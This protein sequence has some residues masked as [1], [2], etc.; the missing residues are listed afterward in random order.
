MRGKR[1]GTASR[2]ENNSSFNQRNANISTKGESE[3]THN[4]N[5]LAKVSSDELANSDNRVQN[6]TKAKRRDTTPSNEGFFEKRD[7]TYNKFELL[8]YARN[9]N[10]NDNEQLEVKYINTI[11]V[12]AERKRRTNF[13]HENKYDQYDK[14]DVCTNDNNRH[15]KATNTTKSRNA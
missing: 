2:V 12:Q 5:V 8:E 13:N 4:K 9:A 1:R 6:D 3:S 10:R 11:T 14:D 7:N 15:D